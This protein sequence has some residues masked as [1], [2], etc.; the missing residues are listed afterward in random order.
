MAD[1]KVLNLFPQGHLFR[2][3]HAALR[4]REQ[5]VHALTTGIYTEYNQ[6]NSEEVQTALVSLKSLFQ[7]CLAITSEMVSML[8][9]KI[10]EEERKRK[11]FHEE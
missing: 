4:T 11:E 7:D 5:V 10:Q 1:Q 6:E 9:E 3:H 2:K 8:D